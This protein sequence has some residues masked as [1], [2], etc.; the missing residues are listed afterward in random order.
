MAQTVSLTALQQ[1]IARAIRNVPAARVRIERA[2]ALIA[3]GHVQRTAIDEFTC[4]SQN[5]VGVH[6]VVSPNG[7]TCIDARRRPEQRCKHQ[8]AA[9]IVLAAAQDAATVRI[10]RAA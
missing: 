7:C 1:T 9:R 10:G 8:W 4:E 6:Y 2:A 5:T 3:L